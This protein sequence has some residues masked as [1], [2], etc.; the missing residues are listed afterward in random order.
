M[1]KPKAIKV[2]SRI[3]LTD[4]MHAGKVNN[5]DRVCFLLPMNPKAK[6]TKRKYKFVRGRLTASH[7]TYCDCCGPEFHASIHKADGTVVV[8]SSNWR[9]GGVLPYC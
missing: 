9:D 4:L 6:Q 8:L 3:H 1:A 2:K 7:K 5:G